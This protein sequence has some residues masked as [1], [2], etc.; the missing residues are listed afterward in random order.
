MGDGKEEDNEGQSR[1]EFRKQSG[2]VLTERLTQATEEE[3]NDEQ[4]KEK[5]CV[6][7]IFAFQILVAEYLGKDGKLYTAF[8][9]SI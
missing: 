6:D 7:K 1:S 5:G 9:E 8:I 4:G 3:I 2:K